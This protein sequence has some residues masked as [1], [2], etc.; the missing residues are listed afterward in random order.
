M[1]LQDI[2]EKEVVAYILTKYVFLNV[3]GFI[4]NLWHEFSTLLGHDLCDKLSNDCK[5]CARGWGGCEYVF[6]LSQKYVDL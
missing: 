3:S 2:G 1:H 5:R 6:W 4:Y